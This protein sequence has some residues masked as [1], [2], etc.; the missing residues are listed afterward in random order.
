MEAIWCKI[1]CPKF[2]L[3]NPGYP[4]RFDMRKGLAFTVCFALGILFALQLSAQEASPPKGAEPSL[5]NNSATTDVGP[6]KSVNVVLLKSW[7]VTSVWEDLK[8]HWQNFGTR[9]VTID[10]STF[11]SSDFTYQDLVKSKANVIVISDPA[12]GIQ[13]YSPAEIAAVAKYAKKGHPVVGTFAVFQWSTIDNRGLA[14]VFGLCSKREYNTTAVGISNQF[15]KTKRNQCLLKRIPAQSWQSN[16]YPFTQVPLTGSWKG[17]LGKATAVAESDKFAGVISVYTAATY[18]G[19]YVSNYPEYNGGT[20]D[21]QLL[22]N[23]VT[24]YAK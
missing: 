13:Q 20:D 19:V 7:G 23:A 15:I 22:Y 6:A 12:G 18:T 1:S 10:D 4:R 8:T 5:A 11:I 16:G 24:C 17:H 3:E 14:P 9:P 2:K 21:E